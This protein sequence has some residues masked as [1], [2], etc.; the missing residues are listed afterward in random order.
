[1]FVDIETGSYHCGYR[2]KSGPSRVFAHSTVL[3][4]RILPKIDMSV[5]MSSQKKKK[6]ETFV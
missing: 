2:K 1:M 5:V 6:E 3:Y 4:R